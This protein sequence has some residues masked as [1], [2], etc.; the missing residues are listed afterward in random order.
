[1]NRFSRISTIWRKEF[2]DTLRDR[3]TVFA[4]VIVPMVLYPALM[5]FSVQAF[6]LQVSRIK[7][8]EYTIAVASEDV[9]HWLQTRILDPDPARFPGATGV[10]AEDL[11]EVVA[12]ADEP[13]PRRPR[14]GLSTPEPAAARKPPPPY[15]LEIV[16]DVI[17]AIA[18]GTAHVGVLVAGTGEALPTPDAPGS[19]QV[20]LVYDEAE[21]RSQFAASALDGVFQRAAERMVTHRLQQEGLSP[22]LLKPIEIIQHS[23]ATP[24]KL[25]GSILG[26]IVALILVVMTFTGAIYPAI[27]LT[28]GE[29][30]RGTLETLMAAPVPTVDLIAGKFVVVASVGMLSAALNLLSIG[31]TVYLAG[32]G[33]VVV[34]GAGLVIPLRTLPLVLVVLIPLAVMF[35]ALLLAVCSF[36]RSFKEAQNYVMP[37]MMVVLIPAM[38]GVL[39][40][41]ELKGPLLILPVTNIVVLTRE[42]FMGEIDRV[43]ILWVIVSTC[44]YAGAAVGVAAKLFGQ[45][46]VLFADSGSIRTL[47]QR[48]FFKP[49]ERPGTAHA[50]LLIAL[51]YSLNFFVQRTLF[52]AGI[53]PGTR[54]HLAGFAL[55]LVLLFAA[56]PL[57]VCLYLRVRITTA[58]SLGRPSWRCVLAAVCFGCSTWILAIAWAAIQER[59]LPLPGEL[60][61]AAQ[62]FGDELARL[63]VLTV[64]FFFALFPAF[65]EE[66]FFRGYALSGLRR[67]LGALGAVVVVSLAFGVAHYSVH[68]LI[69]TAALGGLLGL[70]VVRGNSLWPAMLAHMMH[71]ALIL[72]VTRP[73][74]QSGLE[75][76]GFLDGA[77]ENALPPAPWL[78][79]AGL[80]V[81]LGI[82]MCFWRGGSRRGA[83]PEVQVAQ[84][85]MTTG[86]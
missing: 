58:F 41:A 54:E 75:R 14:H 42:L 70:L 53:R 82:A 34:P 39:P 69:I 11:D 1:M 84:P 65:C 12:A 10:A 29:R 8:E 6:E 67:T 23:V 16:P 22:D 76:L 63:P 60:K 21:I 72:L 79:G 78:I 2:A 83:T 26:Q 73:E 62:P 66:L 36:A 47:F 3:R 19:T 27:D 24:E 20:T 44:L 51:V 56:L 85:A 25:G 71:N 43:A 52:E 40:G 7:Q 33:E 50:L 13:E 28:A 35:S 30:E 45:E 80:A 68:R 61:E 15:R 38:I 5:L 37:V 77:P 57:A 64:V 17:Q 55:T 32:L 49:A 86:G 59:F 74:L 18:A 9:R 4:M 48:R 31:G 81:A 46:A